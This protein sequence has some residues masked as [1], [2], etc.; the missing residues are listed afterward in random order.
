MT[1]RP[2]SDWSSAHPRLLRALRAPGR[3]TPTGVLIGSSVTEPA[4]AQAIGVPF[5]GYADT[6][7]DEDRLR[8]AGCDAVVRNLMRLVDAASSP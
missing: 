3:P 8:E 1:P 2:A 4:A 7:A 5:I 6:L